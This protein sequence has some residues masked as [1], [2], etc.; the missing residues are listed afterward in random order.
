MKLITGAG[1]EATR[2]Y[3]SVSSLISSAGLADREG[4]T[5]GGAVSSGAGFARIRETA[6]STRR[7]ANIRPP[8]IF[9][10]SFQNLFPAANEGYPLFIRIKGRLSACCFVYYIE[11][12]KAC[13]IRQDARGNRPGLARKQ[14]W[15]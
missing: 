7:A 11:A 6:A 12:K 13:Q 14:K 1:K 3:S 10:R 9:S 4:V 2:R 8:R 5:A 15:M